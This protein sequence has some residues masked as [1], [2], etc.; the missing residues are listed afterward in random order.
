MPAFFKAGLVVGTNDRGYITVRAGQAFA[1]S[2]ARKPTD[3]KSITDPSPIHIV[4]KRIDANVVGDTGS[5][6]L[7]VRHGRPHSGHGHTTNRYSGEESTISLPEGH[8]TAE[9][10]N[11]K[12]DF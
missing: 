2:L 6:Q 12:G 1:F 7:G 9:V 5:G 8:H 4:V 3:D 10:R 11:S